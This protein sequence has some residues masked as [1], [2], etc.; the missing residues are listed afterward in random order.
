MRGKFIVIY[1][2]NNIGKSTQ[3]RMLVEALRQRG[4]ETE[5]M[6]F[7]IY[8]LEPTGPR[9]DHILREDIEK[10][11]SE[12]ELQKIYAQNRRDFEPKLR[13]I[14]ERGTWMV[15][16]D[17]TGTGIAWGWTKGAHLETLEK[18]NGGLLKEDAAILLDGE[19]FLHAKERNHIHERQDALTALCREKHQALANRYGWQVVNANQTQ[20]KIHQ[21]IFRLI[22]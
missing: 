5:S 17:Y 19:R 15:A 20:E 9:L 16:E 18:M 3:V 6:K 11:I 8:D 4:T 10:G 14:L 1:G 12:I 13:S 22:K 7:P 21:E 2:I